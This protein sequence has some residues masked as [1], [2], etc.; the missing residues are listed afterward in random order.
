VRVR[1]GRIVSCGE[2]PWEKVEREWLLIGFCLLQVSSE[3]DVDQ[4][5]VV[6]ANGHTSIAIAEANPGLKFVGA[7]F[8]PEGNEC[9]GSS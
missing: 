2:Y 6:V 7:R 1:G 5:Q 4:K 8:A 3:C 9:P